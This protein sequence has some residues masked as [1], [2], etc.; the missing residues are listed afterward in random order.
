MRISKISPTVIL[1]I[2]Y[3]SKIAIKIVK[4]SMRMAVICHIVRRMFEISD[5]NLSCTF[6]YIVEYLNVSK[7]KQTFITASS[8]R[9]EFFFFDKQNHIVC[10][11]K[12]CLFQSI[13]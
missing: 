5:L 6:K 13:S 12:F 1:N 8:Y 4:Q 9:K 11:W 10:N 7:L 3:V 2:K